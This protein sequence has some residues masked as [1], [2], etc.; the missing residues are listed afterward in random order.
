MSLKEQLQ[1]IALKWGYKM[2]EYNPNSFALDVSIKNN[3]GTV[4]YQFV[5][6]SLEDRDPGFERYFISSRCGVFTPR[7]DLYQV[8]LST[9]SCNGCGITITKIKNKDGIEEDVLRFQAAPL[10]KALTTD[11]LD[12][13]IFDVARMADFIESRFFGGDAN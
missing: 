10:V 4:R 1:T 8:L 6:V 13:I 11:A 2:N 7:V 12:D 3:D 5:Y 9:A